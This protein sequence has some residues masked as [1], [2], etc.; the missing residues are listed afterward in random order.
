[1]RGE[2]DRASLPFQ[3]A[4]Q[5]AELSGGQ[6]I[7]PGGGLVEEENRCVTHQ[8]A[9]EMQSLL[10]PSRELLD[11]LIGSVREADALE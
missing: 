2:E 10:H 9:G 11:A 1:V 7:H 6:R 3:L 4:D 8:A 5:R